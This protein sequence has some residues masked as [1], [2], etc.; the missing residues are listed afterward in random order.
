MPTFSHACLTL[1]GRTPFFLAPLQRGMKAFFFSFGGEGLVGGLV[2]DGSGTITVEQT[3]YIKIT[4]SKLRKMCGSMPGQEKELD[5]MVQVELS[6]PI[7]VVGRVI[8]AQEQT[9]GAGS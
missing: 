2:I 7:G 1:W 6:E 5:V 8:V 9:R 4:T 3:R